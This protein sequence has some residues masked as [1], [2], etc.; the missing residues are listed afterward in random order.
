MRY[1]K[2]AVDQVFDIFHTQLGG[3]RIAECHGP[4]DSTLVFYAVEGTVVI[5]QFFAGNNGW[6]HYLASK[7]IK[8]DETVAEIRAWVAR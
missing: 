6:T 8:L 5:V 4:N 2:F 1:N 7:A 3:R